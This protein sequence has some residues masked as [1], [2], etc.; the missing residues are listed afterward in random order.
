MWSLTVALI[1]LTLPVLALPGLAL[2]VLTGW[3]GCKSWLVGLSVFIVNLLILALL[4]YST[5]YPA[6]LGPFFWMW[7]LGAAVA[8]SL[9]RSRRGPRHAGRSWRRRNVPAPGAPPPPAQ[10][11]P[12]GR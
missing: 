11:L 5:E 12:A 9:Y 6:D 4:Y 1:A 3:A 7:V 8:S 10:D 2:G